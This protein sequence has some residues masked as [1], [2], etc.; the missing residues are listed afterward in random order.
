[1]AF[2]MFPSSALSMYRDLETSHFPSN[3][4]IEKMLV[5]SEASGEW[6]LLRSITL[7]MKGRV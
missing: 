7:T 3:D 4:A 6:V 2:G 5:G 1:M